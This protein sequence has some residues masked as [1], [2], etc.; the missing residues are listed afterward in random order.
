MYMWKINIETE[1]RFWYKYLLDKY[2]PFK[3]NCIN[4]N[5]GFI[6]L[7]NENNETNSIIG[8]RK[9]TS[10]I[11]IYDWEKVPFFNFI[12]ILQLS[13]IYKIKELWILD[14]LNVNKIKEK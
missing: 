5:H 12:S 7:I 3:K 2:I 11:E 8:K 13:V 9:I 10:V 14:E 4:C 1:S 6:S